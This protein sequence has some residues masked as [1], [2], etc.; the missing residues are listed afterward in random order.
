MVGTRHTNESACKAWYEGRTSIDHRHKWE[1]NLFIWRM[2]WFPWLV[3]SVVLR[4]QIEFVD[5]DSWKSW[6]SRW[7]VSKIMSQSENHWWRETLIQFWRFFF[8]AQMLFD[9]VN[10][11]IFSLGRYLDSDTRTIQ[12]VTVTINKSVRES[13]RLTLFTFPEE[14]LLSLQR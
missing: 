3:R 4:H 2:G 13:V 10:S 8:C 9:P 7:S 5:I 11:Q 14:W 1:S 6:T 12:E